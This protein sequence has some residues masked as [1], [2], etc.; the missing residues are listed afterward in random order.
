MSIQSLI[1]EN[2]LQEIEDISLKQVKRRFS[3]AI[4][5]LNSAKI[6]LKSKNKE[7]IV[8]YDN[9]Y[10]SAR[11]IGEAFLLLNNYKA[12]IKNHHKTVIE[13]TR[14]TIKDRDMEFL[15]KR[16]DRMRKNRNKLDYDID[17]FDISDITLKNMFEDIKK[18]ANKVEDFINNKDTQKKLI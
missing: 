14:L 4:S 11:M 18:F 2:L 17:V 9:L 5:F 3:V 13:V 10:N 12:S 6:D 16:L 1:E 7:N 8:I 15:F